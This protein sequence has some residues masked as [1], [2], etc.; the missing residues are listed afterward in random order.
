MSHRVNHYHEQLR[1][2]FATKELSEA[3]VDRLRH[4]GN[5]GVPTS[6]EK[7]LRLA[8]FIIERV[9][10]VEAQ[11]DFDQ[12]YIPGD[13]WGGGLGR[14]PVIERPEA[15]QLF[16]TADAGWDDQG[17]YTTFVEGRFEERL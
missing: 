13:G 17:N 11:K 6:D 9:E 16:H 14:P 10:E 7:L 5:E 8:T 2:L 1:D 4:I 3:D 12:V 15:A